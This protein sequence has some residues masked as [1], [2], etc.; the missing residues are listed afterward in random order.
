[1]NDIEQIA[2][3]L[4]KIVDWHRHKVFLPAHMRDDAPFRKDPWEMTGNQLLRLADRLAAAAKQSEA[5]QGYIESNHAVIERQGD[6]NA[7]LAA[8]VES[9]ESL[10]ACYRTG[11]RPA[12]SLLDKINKLKGGTP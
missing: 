8:L 11:R 3:E 9:L 5:D 12:E 2:E 6:E 7:R 4:R 10:L 1:M